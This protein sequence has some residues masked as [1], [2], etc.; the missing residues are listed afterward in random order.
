M[1]WNTKW[2][3]V[4]WTLLVIVIAIIFVPLLCLVLCYCL[5]SSEVDKL[6]EAREKEE[7]EAM[8]KESME[9]K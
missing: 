5:G 3:D 2:S 7:K 6:N 8:D 4:D 9:K 1:V